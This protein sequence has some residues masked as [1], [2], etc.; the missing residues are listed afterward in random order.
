MTTATKTRNAK[1]QPEVL[2]V[3]I[4]LPTEVAKLNDEANRTLQYRQKAAQELRDAEQALDEAN[5]EDAKATREAVQKGKPAPP[6]CL[7]EREEQVNQARR[8]LKAATEVATEAIEA[9]EASLVA[10]QEQ[11]VAK[12]RERAEQAATEAAD[13][14]AAFE[15]SLNKAATEAGLLH[16]LIHAPGD[17]E[18]VRARTR[19][20]TVPRIR[21]KFRPAKLDRNGHIPALKES[22]HGI[23]ERAAG[24]RLMILEAIQGA[25]RPLNTSE[26]ADRI[27]VSALD[28]THIQIRNMMVT[29]GEI[30]LC[31]KDGNPAPAQTP[32][33]PYQV[34]NSH[35]TLGK[36]G[37]TR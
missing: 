10:N 6:S 19:N 31:D 8:T 22:L 30:V 13:R 18:Q 16:G 12:Q 36:T 3:E 29:D 21:R 37:R 15:E 26:I 24:Q 32:G 11:L 9:L 20:R 2:P 5:R 34:R 33:N 1:P 7:P 4:D 14:L 28:P 27:G 17:N 23:Y 35:Y 25:K